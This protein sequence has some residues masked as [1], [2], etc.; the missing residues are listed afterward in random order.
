MD[1]R[2]SECKGQKVD[3]P[4]A[5][6]TSAVIDQEWKCTETRKTFIYKASKVPN[7]ANT[8]NTQ[9]KWGNQSNSNLISH[10]DRTDRQTKCVK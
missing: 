4:I 7:Q 2:T 9:V 10:N 3:V 5:E 8:L 1:G 6:M